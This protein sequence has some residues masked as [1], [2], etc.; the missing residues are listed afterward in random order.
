MKQPTIKCACAFSFYEPF[1]SHLIA[2]S[3][4]LQTYMV[5]NLLYTLMPALDSRFSEIAQNVSVVLGDTE[6]VSQHNKL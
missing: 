5:L 2:R 1:L 3:G 4:P 6:E